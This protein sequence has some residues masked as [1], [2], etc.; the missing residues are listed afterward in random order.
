MTRDDNGI[1][2][3]TGRLSII[4]LLIAK[5]CYVLK[6]NLTIARFGMILKPHQSVAI[7]PTLW[8]NIAIMSLFSYARIKY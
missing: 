2:C 1:E 6:Q 5:I 7:M 3:A 4:F 8:H